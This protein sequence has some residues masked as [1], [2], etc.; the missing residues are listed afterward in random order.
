MGSRSVLDAVAEEGS[1]EEDEDEED[2]DESENKGWLHYRHSSEI[3]GLC[4]MKW[5]GE[6]LLNLPYSV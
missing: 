2:E 1:G 5:P 3:I 6:T 4:L